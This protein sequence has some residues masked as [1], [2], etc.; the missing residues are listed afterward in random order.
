MCTHVSCAQICWIKL[1]KKQC[2]DPKVTA[3]MKKSTS[4]GHATVLLFKLFQGHMMHDNTLHGNNFSV[5]YSGSFKMTKHGHWCDT[6][7]GVYVKPMKISVWILV[8]IF[9]LETCNDIEIK[10]FC[11]PWVRETVESVKYVK[12]QHMDCLV[13]F[14]VSQLVTHPV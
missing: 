6:T 12:K 11:Y 1:L 8:Q 5:M 9:T 7:L 13:T 4:M 3:R 2:L 10:N 14:C